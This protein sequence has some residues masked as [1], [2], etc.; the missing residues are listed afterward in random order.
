MN[1]PQNTLFPQD[2]SPS[3]VYDIFISL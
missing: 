1:S 2:H 3:L